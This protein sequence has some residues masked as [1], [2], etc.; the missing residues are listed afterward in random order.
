M[1]PGK[2]TKLHSISLLCAQGNLGLAQSNRIAGS[3]L[4]FSEA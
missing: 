3:G 1:H 4:S 2:V